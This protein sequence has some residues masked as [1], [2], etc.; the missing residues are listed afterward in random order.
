MLISQVPMGMTITGLICFSVLEFAVGSSVN[1]VPK[2]LKYA[3]K[4]QLQFVCG[5]SSD[6]GPTEQTVITLLCVRSIVLKI[7]S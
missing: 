6:L 5:T 2:Y 7:I 4:S 1:L 3:L